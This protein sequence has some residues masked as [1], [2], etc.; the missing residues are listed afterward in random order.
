MV[1]EGAANIRVE[2]IQVVNSIQAGL[3]L[4][5]VTRAWVVRST[6]TALPTALDTPL[7][8][9]N[10]SDYHVVWDHV[11]AGG[12][13]AAVAIGFGDVRGGEVTH[14]TV[15]NVGARNAIDLGGS[16]QVSIDGNRFSNVAAGIHLEANASGSSDAVRV[17]D[18]TLV[19]KGGPRG[20]TGISVLS[21][22]GRLV[23]N[24]AIKANT[25]RNFG[26]GILI[27]GGRQGTLTGNI[28]RDSRYEGVRLVDGAGVNG[29][30]GDHTPPHT[31]L[32]TVSGGKVLGSSSSGAGNASGILLENAT[33]C[34]VTSVVVSSAAEQYA[35]NEIGPAAGNKIPQHSRRRS[36]TP[37]F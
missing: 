5:G 9:D 37:R 8:A 34:K 13:S 12:G 25:V 11:D 10:G 14:N 29:T 31:A 22:P 19:G 32:V 17:A 36:M 16:R 15:V 33:N 1:F 23:T 7:N 3:A 4:N 35:V 24:F 20:N 21:T 26:T 28:V 30:P 27:A 6:F 18:N 2:S